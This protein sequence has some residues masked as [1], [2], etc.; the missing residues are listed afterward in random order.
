[1]QTKTRGIRGA[2]V[3]KENSKPAIFEA[4]KLVLETMLESN[5][6]I[7][8]DIAAIYFTLTPDLDAAFPAEVAR[9]MGMT[10]VPLLCIQEIGVPGSLERVVRVLMIV[11]TNLTQKEVKHIFLGDAQKLRD[12]L[13][14]E[15]I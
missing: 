7:I 3:V 14:Q 1:L 13:N 9:Q 4:T 2:N 15:G 6:V 10:S 5:Q 11:N 8:D 12:D